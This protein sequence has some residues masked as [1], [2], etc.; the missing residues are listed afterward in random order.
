MADEPTKSRRGCFFYG[1][2]ASSVLLLVILI[3]GIVGMRYAKRMFNE[4]TDT[5]PS[6][7]P[8]VKLSAADLE[9]LEQ[10]IET[11]RE[12]VR[13]HKGTPPLE[14]TP[15]EINGLIATDPDMK[16]LKGKLYVTAI[17]EGRFKGEVSVPM[18]EAGLP[19]FKGRYLNGAGTFA[20]SLRNG[21]L[22]LTISEA[23]VKGKPVPEVYMQKIRNQNLAHN[24]NTDAR[25]QVA[26]DALESIELKPGKLV[27][28]PKLNR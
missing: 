3:A 4:F 17:E 6:Q 11:F 8:A 18:E 23:R 26:L 20:L 28:V 21:L 22:R 13:Q 15:D 9:K 25:A 19:L 1:C 5:Q 24:I 10:R 16:P 12:A 7:F 2:I 14:L 27:I